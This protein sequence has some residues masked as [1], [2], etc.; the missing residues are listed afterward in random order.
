MTSPYLKRMRELEGGL[1]EDLPFPA[2]VAEQAGF[3]IHEISQGVCHSISLMNPDLAAYL[4]TSPALFMNADNAEFDRHTH[5][6]REFLIVITGVMFL[7]VGAEKERRLERGQIAVINPGTRHS[8]RF[9]E[10]KCYYYAITIPQC[11]DWPV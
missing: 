3:K 5:K 7:T 9:P 1:D 6:E 11:A 8:A 4:D 2:T 10:G